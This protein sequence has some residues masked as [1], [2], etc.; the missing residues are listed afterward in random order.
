MSFEGHIAPFLFKKHLH[1]IAVL[2]KGHAACN[3]KASFWTACGFFN[4]IYSG[5]L[6]RFLPGKSTLSNVKHIFQWMCHFI[7]KGF[8]KFEGS[9]DSKIAF[10]PEPCCSKSKVSAI[11][12]NS[13]LHFPTGMLW[14]LMLFSTYIGGCPL[15]LRSNA[16]HPSKN[17]TM[18]A[19]GCCIHWALEEGVLY[20]KSF[21][22]LCWHD[23]VSLLFIDVYREHIA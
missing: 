6:L 4:G 21:C 15:W 8:A 17:A 12:Q 16:T 20:A 7:D 9:F 14:F 3:K 23:Y 18:C 13:M 11:L 10:F 1:R 2:L 22:T 19:K 5:L